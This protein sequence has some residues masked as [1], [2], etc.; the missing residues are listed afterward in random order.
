MNQE[1]TAAV[2]AG[3]RKS[4]G[5]RVQISNICWIIER[6]SEFQKNI[7]FCFIAYTKVFDCVYY[8][9]LW[10]ILQRWEYQTT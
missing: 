8:N 4:R 1:L 5:T 10:K 9:Q 7:Y 6:A 2:Q 3:F